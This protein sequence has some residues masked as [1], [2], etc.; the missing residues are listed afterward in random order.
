[1]NSIS[2]RARVSGGSFPSGPTPVSTAEPLEARRL[3]AAG[4]T[5]FTGSGN[6]A[7]AAAFKNFEAAIGGNDNVQLPP[8]A[9]G[10]RTINWDGVKLD[11]TDFNGN[12]TV[13]VPNK[14]VGIPVNRFQARG[15]IFEEVYAVSG[16]GFV[17]VNPGARGQ[18]NA[19]SPKNTFAM[20]NETSLDLNFVV[21][22]A[23]TTKPVSAAIRGFGA[24]F[25]DVDR[26]TSSFIEFT[27]GSTELGKFF[28]PAGP[29][30]QTEFL[31][32]LFPSA[33]VTHV[34]VVPGDATLFSF[35]HNTV[36]SG[37]ADVSNGGKSDLAA[38]DD[39]AYAEPKSTT[40]FQNRSVTSPVVAGGLA[41]LTGTIVETN[42]LNSF[43]L[44]V[45]W[46]DGSGP[47]VQ[48][49]P[50][51]SDGKVVTLTHRY[52]TARTPPYQIMLDW[53]DQLGGGNSAVLPVQVNPFAL[54]SRH[55]FAQ[56]GR[57]LTG[58][59]ATF[60]DVNAGAAPADFTAAIDWGD[61]QS[62][63]GTVVADGGTF[64]VI[65]SHDYGEEG[66]YAVSV[67]L[68]DGSGFSATA[69]AGA[70]VADSALDHLTGT[71]ATAT[72]GVGFSGLYLG[73][74]RDLDA[75][76]RDGRD[77]SA[78]V[79]W[80]DGAKSTAA[81]EFVTAT[82]EV[83]SHWGILGS[84][85]YSAKGK[86]TVKIKLNDVGSPLDVYTVTSQIAAT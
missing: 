12:T 67:T 72:A 19:F 81:A 10:R 28:V 1:M 4:P 21:P 73:A 13:I 37:P 15:V 78:L 27:N 46:G 55:V 2:H 39:F 68:K 3:L 36:T 31:G 59:V 41:T 45:N 33:V 70:T 42:P 51:G 20:F 43:K 47:Q 29:S 48:T 40:A 57:E 76:N 69:S 64:R 35:K 80:G 84:H 66:H 63:A 60:T 38:V 7:S 17:S 8:Q 52:A 83:G 34:E 86:Y 77:Y 24:I 85:L 71:A 26:S 16:D 9:T 23:P 50:P 6:A 11:G 58:T 5:L 54:V 79:D 56:E 49:F 44:T 53:R 32:V 75:L 62:S 14:V 82:P 18:L 65:G 22:S 25:T 74:F 30:G 61:G